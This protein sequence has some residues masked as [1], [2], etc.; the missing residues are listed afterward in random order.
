MTPFEGKDPVGYTGR[1]LIDLPIGFWG[2]S[3]GLTHD[4][5]RMKRANSALW[6][7]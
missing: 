7:S 2:R 1:S 3:R 5:L 6:R 4:R